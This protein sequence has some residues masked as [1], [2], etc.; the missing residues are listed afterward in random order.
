MKNG[1]PGGYFLAQSFSLISPVLKKKVEDRKLSENSFFAAIR[2]P[3]F[4]LE[5]YLDRSV[6]SENVFSVEKFN[7]AEGNSDNKV[8]SLLDP[9]PCGL[10]GVCPRGWTEL[11]GPLPPLRERGGLAPHFYLKICVFTS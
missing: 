4:S 5:K 11:A 2:S 10:V 7:W 9:L 6:A 3:K 8:F 1:T